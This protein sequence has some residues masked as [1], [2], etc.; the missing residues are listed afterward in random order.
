MFAIMAVG[1]HVSQSGKPEAEAMM[2]QQ[3]EAEFGVRVVG[4]MSMGEALT[5]ACETATREEKELAQAWLD[6]RRN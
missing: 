4:T 2:R 6:A 1:L 5:N 3:L